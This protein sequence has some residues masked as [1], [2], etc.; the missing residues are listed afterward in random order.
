MPW[1]EALLTRDAVALMH[2]EKLPSGSWRVTVTHQGVR[3][4]ATM[5]TKRKA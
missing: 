2:V 5:P 3:R 4:R 1:E